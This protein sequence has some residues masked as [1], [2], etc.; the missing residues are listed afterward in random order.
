MYGIARNGFRCAR[1]DLDVAPANGLEDRA[2]VV[3][4][5]VEGSIPMDSACT[6][7][8]DSGIVAADKESVGILGSVVVSTERRRGGSQ[9]LNAHRGRYPWRA[10][11][12]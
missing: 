9:A 4:R 2:G 6:Q 1:V 5:L 12:Q 8:L 3:C 7:Q 11:G 10:T